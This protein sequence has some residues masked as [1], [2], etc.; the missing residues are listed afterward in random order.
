MLQAPKHP[1]KLSWSLPWC[2]WSCLGVTVSSPVSPSHLADAATSF[3]SYSQVRFQFPDKVLQF[4]MVPI[5][6]GGPLFVL[7]CSP[8]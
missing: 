2:A 4:A 6:L 8:L 5:T 3:H 1:P 7:P